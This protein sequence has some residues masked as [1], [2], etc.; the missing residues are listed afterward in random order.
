MSWKPSPKDGG[1]PITAYIV[2]SRDSARAKYVPAGKTDGET[3]KLTVEKL[4]EGKDYYF[5]VCAENAIGRSDFLDTDKAIVPKSEFGE[6]I[7]LKNKFGEIIVLSSEFGEIIVLSSEFSE[8]IV[9]KNKFGEF[10]VP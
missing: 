9:L 5:R 10:N 2:E 7:V 1:S 4:K 3:C 8:F 6:L